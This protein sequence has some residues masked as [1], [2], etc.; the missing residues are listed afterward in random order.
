MSGHYVKLMFQCKKADR[1]LLGLLI[2]WTTYVRNILQPSFV[3]P[4]MSKALPP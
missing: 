4:S 3:G 1:L 2:N